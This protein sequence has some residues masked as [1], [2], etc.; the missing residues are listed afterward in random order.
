MNRALEQSGTAEFECNSDLFLVGLDFFHG[1]LVSNFNVLC[2]SQRLSIGCL[3]VCCAI[4]RRSLY[5]RE[6]NITI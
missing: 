6:N 3:D 1:S 2:F 4:V 5:F